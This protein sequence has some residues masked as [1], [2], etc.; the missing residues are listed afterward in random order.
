M[1]TLRSRVG[2]TVYDFKLYAIG[3]VAGVHP[4]VV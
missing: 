2:V 4:P 1:T 3:M